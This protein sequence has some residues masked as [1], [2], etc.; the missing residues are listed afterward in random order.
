MTA[1]PAAGTSIH[2]LGDDAVLFHEPRQELHAFNT[3][4]AVIWCHLEDG[5]DEIGIAARLAADFALDPML[6]RRFVADALADWASKGLLAGSVGP[7]HPPPP[8]AWHVP[9]GL[10]PWADVTFATSRDYC[11]A[12]QSFRL[13]C[14]DLA[15]DELL[16][17]VFAHLADGPT[18]DSTD[19]A[20]VGHPGRIVVYRDRQ[21]IGVCAELEALA[22]LMYGLVWLAL[23]DR[24]GFFLDIHAGV[25]GTPEGCILLAAPPGGGKSTLTAALMHAGFPYFSDEVALLDEADFH[26][27]PFPMALCVK[28]FGVDPVAVLFPEVRNLPW[29]H[30]SDGKRV[31]YLPPPPGSLPPPGTRQKVRAVLFPRFEAG[32]A[33]PCR[34]VS[35]M[36][37]LKLLV[38]QWVAISKRL[39]PRH[40]RAVVGWLGAIPCHELV[41]G[42]TDAAIFAVRSLLQSK[43]DEK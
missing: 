38:D 11:L 34:E 3:M 30:R 20:V 2:F 25:L 36:E 33:T 39:E 41:Y 9:P 29:H 28:S 4:A 15:Q 8:V 22:P 13:R 26:V 10:P 23:A 5:L 7:V 1:R 31:T 14:T 35:V 40:I 12:E 21:P 24:H 18:T 17:P 43:P 16:H 27:T 6:A 42:S 37:A 32:A 19:F